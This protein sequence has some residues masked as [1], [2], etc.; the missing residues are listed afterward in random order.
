MMAYTWNWTPGPWEA[1]GNAIETVAT[2]ACVIAGVY[3]ES[4]DCGIDSQSEADANAALIAAAP[5]LYD[6]LE[7]LL[8]AGRYPVSRS[9][10]WRKA[11]KK[12]LAALAAA[13]GETP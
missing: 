7:A 8:A 6:A 5:E 4:D 13:R 9:E 11:E 1:N 10:P 12:A 3:D 2:P